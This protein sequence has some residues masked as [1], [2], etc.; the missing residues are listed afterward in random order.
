MDRRSSYYLHRAEVE[1]A[2]AQTARL[3]AAVRAHYHRAAHYLDR[4]YTKGIEKPPPPVVRLS[5][6]G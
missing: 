2:L 5:Q 3:P 4:A 6:A 1:L